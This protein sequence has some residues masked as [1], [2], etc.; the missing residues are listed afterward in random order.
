MNT[1]EIMQWLR[2]EDSR[3]LADLYRRADAVRKHNVGD[4]IHL[5]GLLEISNVCRRSCAYCG[6]GG[7]HG[8][9]ARYRMT[10]EEIMQGIDRLV[11]LGYGTVVL[12]AGED[13]AHTTEYIDQLVRRIKQRADIAVTL[14]FGER[15]LDDYLQWK[16][17]GADRYLL[18]FETSDPVLFERIHPHATGQG[19]FRLGMLRQLRDAG[20]EVGSG[21]M[22]GIPGQS[23]ESLAMDIRLFADLELDMI[24]LGPYIP[25]PQTPLARMAEHLTLPPGQQVPATESMTLKVLAL[26]RIMCPEAN[27]P[28]TTALATINGSD[29]RLHGLCCGANVVMP[30]LTPM[31]YQ[32]LY[33]IYP[34]KAAWDDDDD[35]HR[36]R[37]TTVLET[38]GRSAGTGHGDSPGFIGRHRTTHDGGIA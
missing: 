22:V 1:P 30:N 3:Q 2:E 35:L 18:R 38:L 27:I 37:I 8:R 21:V 4:A 14:S 16:E 19:N 29:G 7:G 28:S 33:E 17:A 9:I 36:Q 6:I 5:R 31:K 24:G 15:P 23:Y 25:H 20:Y 32:K 10:D 34:A 26:A 11:A 12:Q 13:P